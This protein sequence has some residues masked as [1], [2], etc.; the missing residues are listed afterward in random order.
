MNSSVPRPLLIL[1]RG[2]PGSGKS[3][4]ATHLATLVGDNEVIILDP[5]SIE[6][7]K[8][9][10]VSFCEKLK[11]DGVDEKLFPYRYLRAQAY[12]GM[13]SNKLVVWNQAFTN[14]D[15]VNRTIENISEYAKEHGI[16][17]KS[18]IVEALVSAETAK[19]RLA[20][21]AQSGGHSVNDEAFSRFLIDY[22]PMQSE[23]PI[24]QVNGE[25]EVSQSAKE[26]IERASLL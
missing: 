17:I 3:Y 12:D 25:Q 14:A 20:Q 16:Y 23:V 21:R 8:A 6:T 2:L 10:Y 13:L 19:S 26:I 15:L 5:D 4:I 11:T 1:M 24:I 9:D 18:F 7:D 22:A